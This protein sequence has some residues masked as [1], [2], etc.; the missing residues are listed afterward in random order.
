M[1]RQATLRTISY[2]FEGLQDD[3]HSVLFHGGL[4]G[5]KSWTL[6]ADMYN[7]AYRYP[8]CE[9]A[10]T[11]NSYKQLKRSTHKEVVKY[12]EA[13]KCPYRYHKTDKVFWFPNGSTINELTLEGDPM[14]QKGP[15]WDAI[16]IDEADKTS[17]DHWDVLV[18]RARGKRRWAEDGYGNRMPVVNHRIRAACNPVSPGHHLAE[19]FALNPLPE[20]KFYKVTTYDNAANLP[21]DYIPRLESKYKPGTTAHS[22]WLLGEIISL[23]GAIYPEFGPDCLCTLDDV[24]Q[25]ARLWIGGIDH[26]TVDPFVLLVG[27][28]TPAGILYVVD[29]YYMPGLTIMQHEPEMRGRFPMQTPLWADHSAERNKTLR[30]MGYNVLNAYK[31]VHEG[32]DLVRARFL[33]D[34]I[35]IVAERCPH[36]VHELYNYL[37]KS[38]ASRTKEEPEHRYSHAPDA[39]RY[40]VCGLDAPDGLLL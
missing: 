29:E 37:W 2:Q 23:E 28:V 36:L 39:L 32:I 3:T 6:V 9:L 10:I 33:M 7:Q 19:R 12:L 13:I 25:S 34:G 21:A 24:P 4:G 18:D 15:E 30:D 16:Y 31:S 20:H 8:G 17:V 26:G 40:L 35:R 1:A 27:V 11:N 14:D 38:G 5:A 22:R